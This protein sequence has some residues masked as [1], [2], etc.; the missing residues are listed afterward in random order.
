[1]TEWLIRLEGH[2]FDLE[3]LSDHFTSA[4]RNVKSDTDGYY[5]LR[6]S[7]FNQMSDPDAVRKRA[8]R[9]IELMNAATKL[10]TGGSYRPVQLDAVTQIDDSGKRLH[11]IMLSASS[12][13][14]S[15]M[16]AK[17][18]VGETGGTVNV[19]QPP[20]GAESLVDLADQ[21]E[22]VADALRFYERGNWINLYKAWE[23]VCDAAGGTHAVVNKG[24]ADVA[25]RRR[26]TGTAQSSEELGDEA[27]HAS[28]RCKAP[29]NPMTLYEAQGFVRSVIQAWVQTL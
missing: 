12:E 15:R 29:K 21:N 27:R 23:V 18:S 28:Q 9:L 26:F 6:S 5:Y 3:D 25:E 4:A 16:T 2:K 17:L 7:D 22:K 20:S 1:M 13:G 11:H 24:W 14:R 19:P 10:H 8:L